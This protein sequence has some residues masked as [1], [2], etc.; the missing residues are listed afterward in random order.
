MSGAEKKGGWAAR[1]ASI[2]LCIAKQRRRRPQGAK[3]VSEVSKGE[4]GERRD[5]DAQIVDGIEHRVHDR[6]LVEQPLKLFKR[7]LFGQ[8]EEEVVLDLQQRTR[9]KRTDPTISVSRTIQTRSIS[10]R[11]QTFEEA[12]SPCPPPRPAQA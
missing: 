9:P 8:M 11:R 2:A 5:E 6:R 10:S 4:G 12:D 7:V 1:T 3:G